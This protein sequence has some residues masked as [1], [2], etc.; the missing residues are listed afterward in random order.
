MIKFSWKQINNKFDWNAH[1]VL[2]YFYLKQNLQIPTFLVNK[3]PPKV[4]K[5][6]LV[7]Y[8]RGDCFLINA[9]KALLAATDGYN[10]YMYLELASMRNVFDYSMRGIRYLPLVFVPEY[11][12]GWLEANPMLK[13]E[14]DKVYF[15]YEQE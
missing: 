11:L 7:P 6:T 4:L 5:E 15:K 13:I 1:S 9:E 12:R 2:V 8:P 3:I 10:L 14:N